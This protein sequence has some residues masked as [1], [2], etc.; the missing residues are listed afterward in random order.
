MSPRQK[1]PDFLR[2]PDRLATKPKA[3]VT[4]R[5]PVRKLLF[6]GGSPGAKTSSNKSR[7]QTSTPTFLIK[8]AKPNIPDTPLEQLR[9]P[10]KI[11]LIRKAQKSLRFPLRDQTP[12]RKPQKLM[13]PPEQ[14]EIYRYAKR[15]M[16]AYRRAEGATTSRLARRRSIVRKLD[17]LEEILALNVQKK[18]MDQT[19]DSP[20]LP[21]AAEVDGAAASRV[22]PASPSSGRI[23]LALMLL[24][25]HLDHEAPS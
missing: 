3:Q 15:R 6:P 17:F 21:A 12:D 8:Q 16:Q 20:M 18:L 13:A 7:L 22:A 19:N 4:P 23:N 24:N 9:S 10:R 1:S 11:P 14:E 5:K 2:S 25:V